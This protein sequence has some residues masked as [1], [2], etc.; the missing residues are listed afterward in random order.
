MNT[1]L[2]TILDTKPFLSIN[3]T[4]VKNLTI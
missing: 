3:Q 1:L 4:D 2:R